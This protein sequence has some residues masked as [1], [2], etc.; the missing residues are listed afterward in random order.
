MGGGNVPAMTAPLLL[1]D[2]D[3][4]LSLYGAARAEPGSLLGTQVDGVP[5][6]LSRRAAAVLRGLAAE[7]ECAWCTG[8]EERADE[9]LPRLLGLPRGWPHVRFGAAPALDAH[10]KLAGI[11]AF[12]GPSRALAWIDDAHDDACRAWAASRPA[13]TLLVS[14]APD[15][16]LTGDQGAAVLRWARAI[17]CRSS[18]SGGCRSGGAARRRC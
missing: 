18:G 12:A 13:P 7:F 15:V 2:V 9:H 1:V 14:T 11:D 3:G 16:G 4:V 8:W 6:L 17:R 5:P 10:W